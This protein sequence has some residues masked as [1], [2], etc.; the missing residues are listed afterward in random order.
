MAKR[1]TR[2]ERGTTT[3]AFP[4]TQVAGGIAASLVA[5]GLLR[6]LPLGRVLV[7]AAPMIIAALQ[8]REKGRRG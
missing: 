1:T 4:W 6:R 3:N 2:T 8:K 5:S 7:A